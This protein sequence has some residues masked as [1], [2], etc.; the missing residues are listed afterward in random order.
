MGKTDDSGFSRRKFLSKAVA[1]A[2]VTAAA[3]GANVVPSLAA[4]ETTGAAGIRIPPE[5]A[6]AKT[7]T[8]P[9]LEFPMTGAQVF[10]RVCKE[11]GVAALFCCPGNY[12]VI[13]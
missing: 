8:L 4:V 5:F 6:A 2:G 10:A 9:K 3:L 12:N 7:A 1:G 13:H 11:E